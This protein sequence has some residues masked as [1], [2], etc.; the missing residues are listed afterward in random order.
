[1]SA[2]LSIVMQYMHIAGFHDFIM[3]AWAGPAEF[4]HPAKKESARA[5]TECAKLEYPRAG[6]EQS[7]NLH[8][9]HKFMNN[10]SGQQP[11]QDTNFNRQNNYVITQSIH[12]QKCFKT[13]KLVIR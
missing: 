12:T 7:I 6:I 3:F 8:A 11:Y 2:N 10:A 4:C 9:L 5:H 1:M 13:A